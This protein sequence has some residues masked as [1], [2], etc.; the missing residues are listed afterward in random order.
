MFQVSNAEIIS[1]SVS[2]PLQEWLE[3]RGFQFNPF[4]ILEASADPRLQRYLIGHEAFSAV[5]GNWPAFAFA[6]AGGGKTALRA[7]VF[8]ACWVGQETNRP[9]PIPYSVPYLQWE[10]ALPS[11]DDHLNALLLEGARY[12]LLALAH[13]PHW[14]LR[15]DDNSRRLVRTVLEWNLPG[16]LNFFLEPLRE[17]RSLHLLRADFPPAFLPP[18]VPEEAE[19][20]A[21]LNVLEE[22]E[23]TNIVP[24]VLERWD[25]LIEVLHEVLSLPATYILLD[26]LDA[27]WETSSDPQMA[28]EYLSPLLPLARSWA[29]RR[30]YLKAFLPAET[31]P[32]LEKRAPSA[33]QSIQSVLLE[34]NPALLAEVVR[35]RVYVAS[36]GAYGSLEPLATPN[37]RDIETI[38]ARQISPLPREML[39]LT[40]DVLATCAQRGP[41]ARI[42]SEDVKT[43]LHKYEDSR[44]EF[45]K[46]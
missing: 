32:I 39:V 25:G 5:W 42:T 29:A 16:P 21:F 46:I 35:R 43:A 18:Q 15:L 24:G 36:N 11:I 13:R 1:S 20:I 44:P 38:L 3:A 30:I 27:V 8:Q 40:H 12:L 41:E 10:Y 33:F 17:S 28:V 2:T 23:G 45:A 4:T 14:F 31:R 22:T 26:G 6:P 34:W 9:F 7:W 19:L 37:L